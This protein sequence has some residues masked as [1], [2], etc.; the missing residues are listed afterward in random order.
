MGKF[1]NIV[2]QK[3]GKLLIL[4]DNERKN[5]TS[6]LYC[7]CLCDCGNE[8]LIRKSCIL[9]GNTKSCGCLAKDAHKNRE[10]Y[11]GDSDTTEYT[12]YT[13][14]KYRCYNPKN[15]AYKDYGG[16]GITVCDRWMGKNGYKNFI[17]DMGYKNNPELTLERIDNE[18]GYSPENCIW[19]TRKAQATNR[20]TTTKYKYLGKELTLN[21]WSKSTGIHKSTLYYRVIMLKWSIKKA[22]ETPIFKPK[23]FLYKNNMLTLREIA[24]EENIDFNLLSTRVLTLNWNLNRAIE[25]PNRRKNNG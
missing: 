17:S 7:R 15:H 11:H 13:C 24:I 14:M 4:T 12:T 16:R 9:N 21:E 18:K 19:A 3:F 6:N 23:T 5:N 8:K 22:I 25:T 20:R 10:S 1:K 2:G